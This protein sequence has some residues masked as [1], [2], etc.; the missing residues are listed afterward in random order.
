MLAP[1]DLIAL[2]T[3]ASDSETQPPLLSLTDKEREIFAAVARGP[4]TTEIA[5]PGFASEST[6]KTH[7]G[8]I[9]GKLA[10]RDRVQIAC[11]RTSMVSPEAPTAEVHRRASP[12]DR[13]TRLPWVSPRRSPD[14]ATGPGGDPHVLAPV[15]QSDRAT[16]S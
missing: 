14:A 11:S 2:L 16:A 3:A 4:S 7:V 13:G 6:V 12:P 8:G 15:A 5:G 9:L 1:R 10:L